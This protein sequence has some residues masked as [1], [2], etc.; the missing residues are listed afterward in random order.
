VPNDHISTFDEANP[1]LNEDRFEI[2]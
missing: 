1:E 2:G